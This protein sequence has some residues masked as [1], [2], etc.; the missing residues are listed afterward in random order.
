MRHGFLL[1]TV[2]TASCY[3]QGDAQVAAPAP[4]PAVV[5]VDVAPP[6]PQQEVIVERTG[7]VWIGGHWYRNN[8][9]WVW[10]AGYFERARVGYR[11]EPGHYGARHVWV[12]GH[13]AR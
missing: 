9:R 10:H 6:P 11:W 4:A 2:F 1:A 13:W 7:F 12:E 3:V 8:G 5:E